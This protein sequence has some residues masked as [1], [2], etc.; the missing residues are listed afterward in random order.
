MDA[1]YEQI[2]AEAIQARDM[3][4][5]EQRY[6]F[7]IRY[8]HYTPPPGAGVAW[9]LRWRTANVLLH[10]IEECRLRFPDAGF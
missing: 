8:P 4:L 2:C 3:V 1:T 7:Q 6:Q 9:T 5:T 10:G